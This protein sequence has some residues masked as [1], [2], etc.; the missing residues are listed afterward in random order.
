MAT[1]ADGMSTYVG[2]VSRWIVGRSVTARTVRVAL[3]VLLLLLAGV[4]QVRYAFSLDDGNL[5]RLLAAARLNPYDS[6]I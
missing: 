1:T 4:D 6:T 5:P 3:A 2:D